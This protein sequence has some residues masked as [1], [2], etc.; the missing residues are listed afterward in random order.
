[1]ILAKYG[2]KYL[3][4][5]AFILGIVYGMYSWSYDRG[6]KASSEKCSEILLKQKQD[7]DAKL[8]K[9]LELSNTLVE[10]SDI[11]QSKLDSKLQ[12]LL[13]ASKRRPLTIVKD[14]KCIPSQEFSDSFD[15]ITATV[16]Q[17]IEDS[18]K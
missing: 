7:L 12:E 9:V 6:Y 4:P 8:H 11:R 18:Q 15:K 2:I 13:V 16:N 14:G 17:N 1:M 3:L 5:L 10:E